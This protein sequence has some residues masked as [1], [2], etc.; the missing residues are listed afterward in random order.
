MFPQSLPSPSFFPTLS[1]SP[2]FSLLSL[3][4]PIRNHLV[5]PLGRVRDYTYKNLL[6]EFLNGAI[7]I[8]RDTDAK[9]DQSKEDGKRGKKNGGEKRKERKGM[10]EVKRFKNR[11]N[12]PTF[13][14]IF[15]STGEIF[16][17]GNV[18]YT[19]NPRVY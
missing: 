3:S 17:Q 12:C 13:I 7:V 11:Q 5:P 14:F 15:P 18:Y 2:S 16:S 9:F 8:P 4:P 6:F 10:A 1:L 19:R